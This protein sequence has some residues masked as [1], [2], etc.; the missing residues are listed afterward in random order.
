MKPPVAVVTAT[1]RAVPRR[2]A[3]RLLWGAGL[4]MA[5]TGCSVV[6]VPGRL[7]AL[8]REQSSLGESVSD[9]T[10]R[11]DALDMEMSSLAE[12]QSKVEAW[13]QRLGGR[14][15]SAAPRPVGRPV[16]VAPQPAVAR[17]QIVRAADETVIFDNTTSQNVMV[18]AVPGPGATPD[19][20]VE[21]RVVSLA[22]TPS[23]IA[24]GRTAAG[25]Y[26]VPCGGRLVASAT[27]DLLLFVEAEYAGP[28]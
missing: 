1:A 12:R 10:T 3:V 2:Y 23:A 14:S 25:R 5:M 6:E 17:R 16:A 11:Y 18:R 13:I 28:C 9:L 7:E 26:S 4:V 22:D 19:A 20:Q 8:E 15:G 27:A 21:M 24:G